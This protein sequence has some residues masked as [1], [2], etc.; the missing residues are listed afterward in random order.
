MQSPARVHSVPCA[1]QHSKGQA[2]LSSFQLHHFLRT[3]QAVF[4]ISETGLQFPWLNI[5]L[6][7]VYQSQPSLPDGLA[8]DRN[9][10]DQTSVDLLKHD[11]AGSQLSF[12][13]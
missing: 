7:T 5:F 1:R 11:P 8:T 12:F 2:T 13:Q 9:W 6:H 10:P 3:G 4:S